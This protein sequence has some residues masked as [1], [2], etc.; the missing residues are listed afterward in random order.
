MRE[1]P[2]ATIILNGASPQGPQD[3][4]ELAGSIKQYLVN[5]FGIDGSRIATQGSFKAHPP[6]EHPGGTKDLALLGAENRRV[7]IESASPE[8]LAE[9]GERHDESGSNHYY[10]GKPS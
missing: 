8:L 6:S 3:G 7:E 5:V 10:A 9:V 1:N 2:G 4:R